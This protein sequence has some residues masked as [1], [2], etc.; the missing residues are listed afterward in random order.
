VKK[1]NIGARLGLGFAIVL[2]LLLV[3]S[4]TALTRMQSAADLTSRLVNTSIK[5][6]RNLAEWRRNI[7]INSAINETVYYAVDSGILDV[8]GPRRQAITTRSNAL[9]KDIEESLRN[10]EVR[11]QFGL[12]KEE[13]VKYMAARDAL[14]Q[15]KRDGDRAG[16]DRVYR[17]ELTPRT[18]IYLATVDKLATMQ[19]SATDVVAVSILD[20]Y[21]STRIILFVLGGAALLLGIGCAWFITRSITAPLRQAVE[22]AER[23]ANGDLSSRFTVDR[24]DEVGQLMAALGR[25]NANLASIVGRVRDGTVTIATASGEIA[26]GNQD[27]STRT[28][29]QASSLE[30][31][32]ASME[33]LTSTVRQNTEHARRANGL[34]ASA[35]DVASEGGRMVADVVGTM[36]RIDA[37]SQRI[38]DIIGVIDGIAFQTNIL[39]LNAAVEAARAGEQGRGFAVVAGEV[40]T[41]AHRSAAA[42][43][44]IKG[45]IDDSVSQVQQGTAQ[46]ARAGA[47]MEQIVGSIAQVT[48][49]MGEIAAASEE[50]S[51]GIEQV[52]TA[53]LEMD[54]VTQ[55]NAALVEEAAAAAD[56][57]RDQAGQLAAVVGTFRLGAA[58]DASPRDGQRR[59][60]LALQVA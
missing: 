12:V 22:V 48:V 2:A 60:H 24:H 42:A 54:R 57:M 50:Q 19:I 13:R 4:A 43:K 27:L 36:G 39:A 49:I 35:A 26:S 55:Q 53:I 32:A 21:G 33:E 18:A 58:A 30:E 38:V 52:N 45:L 10:P 59:P 8:I 3:M 9:Q 31:T 6:Q 34:A 37:S 44:E 1:L 56:A 5:N 51:A 47:T 40:R 46:V 41:L 20:S 17:D 23:V 16:I 15:A 29:Q 7:E 11:A 28:E 14:F 25:M